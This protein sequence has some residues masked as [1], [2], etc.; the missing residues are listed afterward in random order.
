[1]AD[2]PTPAYTVT[3]QRPDYGPGPAG[4]FVPGVVVSFT[5]PSGAS[6]TV[7]I[8][9][10]AYTVAEAAKRIAER[11]AVIEGIAALGG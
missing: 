7:F 10:A 2:K 5:T 11:V 6:G 9:E 8:P 1:M 3:A 4:T